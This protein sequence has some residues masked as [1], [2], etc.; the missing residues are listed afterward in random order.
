M[1]NVEPGDYAIYRD[2]LVCVR[3]II[4]HNKICIETPRGISFEVNNYELILPGQILDRSTFLRAWAS[5]IENEI[6]SRNVLEV[7]DEEREDWTKPTFG[8][9]A[10]SLCKPN[11]RLAKQKRTVKIMGHE[12]PMPDDDGDWVLHLDAGPHYRFKRLEDRNKWV[13]FIASMINGPLPTKET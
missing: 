11:V 9:L 3:Y 12:L 13:S 1:M 5:A 8:D 10:E 6:D 2:E 4:L 7:Y